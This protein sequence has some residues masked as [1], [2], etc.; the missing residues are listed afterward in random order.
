MPEPSSGVGEP[1]SGFAGFARLI[2]I[3]PTAFERR[4]CLAATL[5]RPLLAD[6]GTVTSRTYDRRSRAVTTAADLLAL[7]DRG[8]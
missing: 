1:A 3:G 6:R 4:P 8:N 7:P 2:L 5:I